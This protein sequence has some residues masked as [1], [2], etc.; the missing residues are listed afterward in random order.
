MEKLNVAG[1]TLEGFAQGGI[2]TSIACPEVGGLFDCGSVIPTAMRYTKVFITHGHPDHIGGLQNLIGRRS[3]QDVEPA[4]VHVPRAVARPLERIFDLWREINGGNPKAYRCNIIPVDVGD[5]FKTCRDTVVKAVK[6]FHRI[7]SVGWTVERTT[8]RLKPIYQGLKGEDIKNLRQQGMDVTLV[9]KHIMLTIPGDTSIEFLLQEPAARKAKVLLHE[10]TI[11]D[12]E[13][14]SVEKTR[15]YG[16]TH[17]DEMIEHCE[18]FEGEALVL[19]HR[20][21]RWSRKEVEDIVKTRFPS[22]MKDKIHIFD[23]G[24]RHGPSKGIPATLL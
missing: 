8:K 19:V 17:V 4:D 16:H 3:I 20:S 1:V 9:H 22:S 14:S 5:E 2:R 15:R 21:M 12:T 18:K 7:D 11:W 6:T 10:V 13:E 23:G 24:D